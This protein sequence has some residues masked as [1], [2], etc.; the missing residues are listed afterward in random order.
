MYLVNKVYV[1][2]LHI[3]VCCVAFLAMGASSHPVLAQSAAT[4]LIKGTIKDALTHEPLIGV[5]IFIPGTNVGASSDLEGNFSLKT[6]QPQTT[7]QFTYLGYKPKT[8]T[9]TPGQT[10]ILHVRLESDAKK[11][12]EVVIKG[13]SRNYSNKNNPA[14]DLIRLVVDHKSQNRLESYDN[15][16]YQQYDKLQLALANT[17]EK[18]S[19]NLLLKKYDFLRK[20]LDT[21]TLSGT[22]LL[23]LYMQET[24]SDQFYRKDPEKK[25]TL[26]QAEKK[27]DFG[28]FVVIKSY[29][30][31]MYQDID[32]YKNNITILT[33]QFLSPIA[34]L[35]PTFYR[36]YITDTVV[37]DGQKLTE[38]SFSP[39]NETDFLFT[40]KLYVTTDGRYAV[41]KVDMEVGK[42]VN[43]N[44]V[45]SLHIQQDFAK[46][47]DGR[48]NLSKSVVKTEFA[49]LE[50]DKGGVYGERTV[51]YQDY[52]VNQPQ[53]S[54]F[55]EGEALAQAPV[56]TQQDD[57]FWATHRPDSLSLSQANTYLSM[58]SLRNTRSF[59]RILDYATLFIAGYKHA[60]PYVEIGPVNT[61]YSFNPVE[62]FRLR[63]GGRTTTTF[64]KK[65]MLES[66]AA[67][68]FK[69]EKWK[70]YL[71][72]TYSFTDRSI[73]AFPVRALRVNYQKDTKIP[74]QDLQFV[75]EDNFLLSFKR[76]D[77]DKWLYNETYNLDYLHELRNHFS[78]RVGF[79]NWKQ[80]P[81]GSLEYLKAG[82][83][84]PIEG[85]PTTSPDRVEHLTT[86]EMRLELRWA[87]K[88]EFVQGK[89]Y[90]FPIVNRYPVFT[91]RA[92]AGVKG[93]FNGEYDYQ[94]LTLN[95]AKRF[96]LSQVGFSDVVAE[97]GYIFGQVPFPLLSIH[98]ANQSYSYQ[99][100]AY[101]L[102]NF[103][104]FVSDQYVSL[105]VDLCFNGFLFNKLPLIKHTKLREFATVKVLYGKVREENNPAYH[106]EL[107]A[108]PTN[109]LGLPFTHSLDKKPYVEASV[110]VGNIFKFFRLDVV[111]RLSYLDHPGV[112]ELGLRG[113]FKF[114]F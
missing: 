36:F 4:T 32:L 101:N 39:K 62:G 13:R 81:A 46:L 89:L 5:S 57:A 92:A 48:Y 42:K 25:R 58:D 38:L 99:L 75:Q 50:K 70:Y 76:G 87:P 37:V 114:D 43:I 110:G 63:A 6:T 12:N 86:S 65:V 20:N 91:L 53:P 22:A 84:S 97:G 23:P 56:A 107:L 27:V 15:V 77:N 83:V 96:Y 30:K 90:R 28:E 14:V 60:G 59:K 1:N 106:Q 21:T 64:S 100:Q 55:Y 44:W 34:D 78:F 112:S 108:F 17:P 82:T 40:G 35:A 45:R 51:T 10:Q 7:I 41:Q 103:L 33:N 61:F 80:T 85:T 26:V 73:F 102:M 104:E 93:P 95:A 3:L 11:L 71:G 2:L 19:N 66:Y 31:H 68:G 88:E 79:K 16:Q 72:G 49:V 9:F 74:G 18:L 52:E 98:R 105:H 47:A 69:D 109:P 111:K 94:S 54:N 113:R 67:Y 24:I 29:V 8:V